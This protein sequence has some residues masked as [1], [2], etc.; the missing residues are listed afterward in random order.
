MCV[1]ACVCARN[2]GLCRNGPGTSLGS[3]PQWLVAPLLEEMA[4]VVC[5]VAGVLDHRSQTTPQRAPEDSMGTR[6]AGSLEASCGSVVAVSDASQTTLALKVRVKRQQ[7]GL[8]GQVRGYKLMMTISSFLFCFLLSDDISLHFPFSSFFWRFPS[9][10]SLF[11]SCHHSLNSRGRTCL[12]ND[13]VALGKDFALVAAAAP[14]CGGVGVAELK[15]SSKPLW[16][17]W[18]GGSSLCFLPI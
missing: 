6:Q 12:C 2:H 7:R 14:A 1:C 9:P 5:E 3:G 17:W 18:W 16:P 15:E 10:P 4:A 11:F 13:R 8:G